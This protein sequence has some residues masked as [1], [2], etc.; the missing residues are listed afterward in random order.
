MRRKIKGISKAKLYSARES[1]KIKIVSRKTKEKKVGEGRE[2]NL[3]GC[4]VPKDDFNDQSCRHYFLSLTIACFFQSVWSQAVSSL[5]NSGRVGRNPLR[6]RKKK[7]KKDTG[8]F[9]LVSPSLCSTVP[10]SIS[11]GCQRKKVGYFFCPFSAF[12]FISF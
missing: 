9:L 3:W 6:D 11:P 10:S 12:V 4:Q 5:L 1:G 8:K 7:K 2:R